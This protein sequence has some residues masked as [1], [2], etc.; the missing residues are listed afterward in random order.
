MSSAPAPTID[1]LPIWRPTTAA[2]EVMPPVAVRMPCDDVH[3][4]NVV[5]HGLAADENDRLALPRP[6]DGVVGREHDLAAGRAGR[7]RQPLRRRPGIFSHSSGSKPGASSW[8]SDSGID[9]QHRLF[10]RDQLLVDEIGG[11][12]DRRVA[13]AL[14]AARLQHEQPLVLDR[15]LEVLH[16]LVVLLEPRR[17]LAQL[18]V[19][20]RQH[21]FELADRL[22][23]AHAGDDVLALRVDQELAVE[24]LLAGAGIAR[25]ADAGRRAVAGVAEHHH[26]HVDGRADVIGDVVDAAV[27]FRA[28][29]H[30]R[31]EHRVARHVQ[32][33]ARI[34][35]ERPCPV[36]SLHD[37]LVALDD[38]A[39]RVLVEV[40][41]E[42]R[43]RAPT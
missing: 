7:R 23:R 17:D 37:P 42:L 43:A 35:R 26:L 13:G 4:V 39:Q 10:R 31:A 24:L 15:E 20:L 27:F 5:R 6:L 41:V 22:R 18:L 19:G 30:P 28:R 25:K 9:Q 38:F 33:L 16:V 36:C 40:G 2:C 1:G 3:A 34:L 14:A 29:V 11:D 8:L 21:L 12:H 32:L